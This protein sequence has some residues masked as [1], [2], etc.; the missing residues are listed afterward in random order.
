MG[1][2]NTLGVVSPMSRVDHYIHVHMH[3]YMD[4]HMF[5]VSFKCL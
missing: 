1:S 4:P 3:E 2:V 5:L